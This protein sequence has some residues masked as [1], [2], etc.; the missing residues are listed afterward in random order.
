VKSRQNAISQEQRGRD[1]RYGAKK[2]KRTDHSAPALQAD[3]AVLDVPADPL[4]QEWIQS[5]LPVHQE[6]I[7]L[8][9]IA[10]TGSSDQ[11]S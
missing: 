8:G 2:G 1:D 10:P 6:G 3:L 11:E 5:S 4:A 7:E 9:A